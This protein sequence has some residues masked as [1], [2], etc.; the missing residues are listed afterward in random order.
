MTGTEN[1]GIHLYQRSLAVEQ[2]LTHERHHDSGTGNFAASQRPSTA[3]VAPHDS[4]AIG[5]PLRGRVLLDADAGTFCINLPQEVER[6][7][8]IDLLFRH[9]AIGKMG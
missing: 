8:D 4:C 1:W 6:E 9:V 5:G 3:A 2:A 7:I